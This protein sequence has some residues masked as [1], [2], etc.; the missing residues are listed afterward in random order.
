[1]G[2]WDV[3]PYDND[4]ARD[5]LHE[6]RQGRFDFPLFRF[7]CGSAS[8]LDADDAAVIIA[9]SALSNSGPDELP[10]GITREHLRPFSSQEA[11][12]WLRHHHYRIVAREDS[13]LYQHWE[14][15]GEL[16]NW[17]YQARSVR[18]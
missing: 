15:T 12:Q 5:M 17:L 3:G 13:M 11:K 14:A 2:T 1:M 7:H 18:P 8:P 16:E 10:E 6:L 9:L 4:A